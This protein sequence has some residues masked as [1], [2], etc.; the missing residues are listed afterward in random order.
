MHRHISYGYRGYIY[1]QHFK[2]PQFSFIFVLHYSMKSKTMA[3]S[4][5]YDP[6]VFTF[7]KFDEDLSPRSRRTGSNSVSRW[8]GR[9]KGEFTKPGNRKCKHHYLNLIFIVRATERC[10]RK[11]INRYN[12]NLHL[13]KRWH[14]KKE[15][16]VLIFRGTKSS[17]DMKLDL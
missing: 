5:S 3:S 13:F 9:Y 15:S 12:I 11:P 7:V 8:R 1:H 16:K 2:F 17:I 4:L 10:N 6:M 14:S